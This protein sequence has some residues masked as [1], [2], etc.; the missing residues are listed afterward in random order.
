MKLIDRVKSALGLHDAVP[1]EDD[2]PP[3]RGTAASRATGGADKVG[4]DA[5]A[6]TGT[7][8]ADTFVGRVS[9]DDIGAV[10]ETGAEARREAPDERP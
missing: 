5:Q 3:D 6:T 2:V 1:T 7:G 9:G 8:S 10:G 4:G